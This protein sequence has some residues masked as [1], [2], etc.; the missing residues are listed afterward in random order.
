[1]ASKS[2]KQKE[3]PKYLLDGKPYV[4]AARTNILDTLRKFG[5]VPPSEARK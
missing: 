1:M 3:Q 2:K 4:P 5:W